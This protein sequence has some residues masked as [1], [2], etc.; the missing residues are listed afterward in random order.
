MHI[1]ASYYCVVSCCVSLLK[2]ETVHFTATFLSSQSLNV[3][4]SGCVPFPTLEISLRA[5]S[6]FMRTLKATAPLFQSILCSNTAFKSPNPPHQHVGWSYISI[7]HFHS[8]YSKAPADLKHCKIIS[9]D[10][11]AKRG[12][13]QTQGNLRISDYYQWRMGSFIPC[14]VLFRTDKS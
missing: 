13:L 12:G 14:I 8:L 3:F 6:C 2:E 11:H 9:L 1:L 5:H 7:P 10:P 4:S